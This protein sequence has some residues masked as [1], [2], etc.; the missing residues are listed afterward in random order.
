M[1]SAADPS[2]GD[3]G[4][5]GL[6]GETFNALHVRSDLHQTLFTKNLF[7]CPLSTRQWC[8]YH[9][10]HFMNMSGELLLQKGALN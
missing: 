8:L 6:Y 1:W 3:H 5:H 9:Q 2:T 10:E 4:P 7:Y